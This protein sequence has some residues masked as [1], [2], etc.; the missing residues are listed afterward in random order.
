MISEDCFAK[1]CNVNHS[2]GVAS[3]LDGLI[4]SL[5][6]LGLKKGGEVI[7]AGNSYFASVLSFNME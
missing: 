7:V 1:Y 3:G 2:V 4:L 6:A 5:E